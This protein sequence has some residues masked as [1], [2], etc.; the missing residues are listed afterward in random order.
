ML[1]TGPNNAIVTR[2]RLSVE[3]GD[4]AFNSRSA[5][6]AIIVLVDGEPCRGIVITVDDEEGLVRFIP[7]DVEGCPVFDHLA[8]TW[9]IM[10]RHGEVRIAFVPEFSQRRH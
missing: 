1:H 5:Q 10:E 8:G 9:T 6:M 7:E 4:P 3:K 2:M